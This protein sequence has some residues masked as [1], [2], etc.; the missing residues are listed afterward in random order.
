M[1]SKEI[2]SGEVTSRRAKRLLYP[3]L[4]VYLLNFVS[5]AVRWQVTGYSGFTTGAAEASGYSVVEHGHT[6]H[7]TAGQY[8]LG[9]IQILILIVGV[10]AWFVA[11]AY[12]FRTGDLRREKRAA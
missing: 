11:R 4:V 3:L 1:I 2:S 10:V 7:V 9:R 8:W 12:F 5:S 6:I